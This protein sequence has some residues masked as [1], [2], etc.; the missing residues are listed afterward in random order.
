MPTAETETGETVQITTKRQSF[1]E[2]KWN[3]KQWI[4]ELDGDRL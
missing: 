2:N 1:I 4:N 3:I